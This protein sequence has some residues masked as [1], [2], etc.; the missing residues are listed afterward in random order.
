MVDVSVAPART[1]GVLSETLVHEDANHLIAEIDPSPVSARRLRGHHTDTSMVATATFTTTSPTVELR[2]LL[3]D[4]QSAR[5][6]VDVR[7]PKA[8]CLT[9]AQSGQSKESKH[10]LLLAREHGSSADD[11]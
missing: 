5:G 8:A 4:D 9:A 1:V 2:H 7:P 3:A 11:G 10:S 6:E